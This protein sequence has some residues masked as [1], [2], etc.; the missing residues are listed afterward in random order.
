MSQLLQIKLKTKNLKLAF[1]RK[2]LSLST[3]QVPNLRKLLNTAKF[4][5]LPIPK[6]IKQAGFFP[7]A[8]MHLS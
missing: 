3:R 1:K 6:Q 5:R 4:E 7:C 2:K 8:R